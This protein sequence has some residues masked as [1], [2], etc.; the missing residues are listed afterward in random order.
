[1]NP[2]MLTNL[3]SNYFGQIFLVA[4]LGA[5][6][7]QIWLIRRQQQSIINNRGQVPAPFEQKITVEQHHK[8]A[9]YTLAKSHL[10]H[11][12]IYTQT[13]LVCFW[14]FAGG[15]EWLDNIARQFQLSPILQGTLFL[16]S[17]SL[18]S[19]VFDIPSTLYRTFVIEEKFG[20]NHTT[21]KTWLTDGIK[22]LVLSIIIG[23]P[24][25]MVIIWLMESSGE[26]W[27][28]YVWAVWMGFGLLISW[29]FPTFIAP[30]FN[31]FTPLEDGELKQRITELFK[32]CGFNSK[33]IFVMDG[34]KRSAHGNAY[35]TG[36]G[37]SK[38]IVF[39][40]TLI[41][42]LSKDEIEA[43]LAHELGHF[44]HKHII[45]RLIS[46]ALTSLAGLALLGWLIKQT[47]FYHTLGIS[48]PSTYAALALFF[49]IIPAFT[50]Y[51]APISSWFSRKHEFEA[52]AFAA[53]QSNPET[54][55]EAL[56]KLYQENANTLTPDHL[57]SA[58]HD[59]HPP[60]LIRV[61]HL[62]KLAPN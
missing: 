13:L 9:D 42:S 36:F 20:F 55:I 1:M 50:L 2:T 31:K 16:F 7:T 54:L 4:L 45:K 21:L 61:N 46:G 62:Q 60:A 6:M 15:L 23:M 5:S 28:L 12:D 32:R 40:D 27:W 53:Q 10:D 48:Q 39:F 14:I 56:V 41:E 30:L 8:A 59:S 3:L 52:D 47:W 24:L 18:I 37:K 57:Y 19:S 33:G 22:Q 11:I 58:F 25:L 34:S 44:K 29:A 51:F 26:F 49:M 43:V 17:L 35:F 38:R